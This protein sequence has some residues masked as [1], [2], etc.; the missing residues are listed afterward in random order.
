VVFDSP[1]FPSCF[2]EQDALISRVGA[3]AAVRKR[4][5]VEASALRLAQ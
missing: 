4:V 2:E 5:V 3:A 1:A